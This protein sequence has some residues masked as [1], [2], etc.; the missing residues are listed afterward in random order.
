MVVADH[1]KCHISETIKDTKSKFC[2]QITIA[3]PKVPK[4]TNTLFFA[5]SK[6]AA[7][8]TSEKDKPIS[9]QDIGKFW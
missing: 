7:A 9:Q 4:Y 1:L 6:T 5:K 8:A 2:K 3:M